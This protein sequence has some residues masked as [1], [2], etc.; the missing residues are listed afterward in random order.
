MESR[1]SQGFG[2][3]QPAVEEPVV[4]RGL[5]FQRYFSTPG[6][7]P[8]S[9]VEW[10]TRSAVITNERGEVV[11]EQRDVEVPAFWSQQATNIVVSKYF[12]GPLKGTG[13]RERSVRQLV[14]RVVD[15]IAS[16]ARAQR[17]FATEAD[18]AAFHDD[19]THLMLFQKAAFN[20]P[21]WFNCGIEPHPQCSA[22]FI[23][24]VEDT[25]DSILTLAK[26]EGM[27]FK[28]GSGT[29]TNLSTLRSS[30]ES[31]AGGGTAS[32]PVSFMKGYD[33]FAG[34]IKSGGKTRRAAKM[35][36]LNVDHP[37]IVDFIGCKVAEEKKAWALIDAGYDGS[38]TG[39]A[40]SSVFFQNSNNSVRVPDDFMRAV[41]DGAEWQTKAVCDGRPMETYRAAEIMRMIAEATYIC[42]DPGM[43]FDTTINEWHTCPNSGRINASNPCSEYMFLD[44][45]ACNLA[46]INLMRFVDSR[47]EFDV[48]AFCAAIRT[49]ITAQEI[50]VDNASYP[51][52]A[53]ERNSHE[54]RPLGLGYANLGALLMSRGLPY[55]SDAGRDYAAAITALMTGEAY[56][57]SARIARDNGGPFAGYAKNREPFLRVMAKHR[58]AL[59]GIDEHH[60]PPEIF[61]AARR[62]WDEAIEIGSVHGFRNAQT[63][64][65]APTGTIGFM[66]DCD[67]TGI[68]PDIALVKYKKLVDGGLLKIVNQTVP[69][70][71]ARLGYPEQAIAAIVDYIDRNETI[72]GAPFLKEADLAVFDCAFKPAKG[73]RSI[74]YLGHIRMMG[75]VQPFISGA[76]SKTV[77]VPR[78]ASVDEIMQAYLE[79]WRLGVK[80]IS[81]YRDG[82]KRTQPL[83]TSKDRKSIEA[84]VQPVRR[85]LP[86][87]RKAITHKFDIAGHEGYITVGLYED[88]SPGEIFLVMAK[89]GSTISG[90]ADAF[91]QAVSYALQYGVPLQVLVD[92]FSHVRFE[93]SGVTRNPQVRIAKSIVDYVFRWLATKFLS[94]EA[95]FEAG[96]NSQ[97][98]ASQRAGS[99]VPK[100]LELEPVVRGNGVESAGQFARTPFA[101]MQNQEDAP[102]CTTCGSI[103]VRSGSCYKCVNCGSTS[104]CA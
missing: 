30:R 78:E 75:A 23:N 20:S 85:K 12:R 89:E 19:L 86:D 14:G 8:Y 28:F 57:Q 81:I 96:V 1:E 82:S 68:E 37:D 16:W 17:Y 24:S 73:R 87:E 35:V 74:H 32:G 60:V 4:K 3:G 42:G 88:G 2:V 6:S 52:K 50:L 46:S 51:T 26:T 62:A 100:Q 84:K 90:F 33:A 101:A 97:A 63:T 25:L 38:F 56:A 59:R 79:A 80:A 94:P 18:L 83:N 66:M 44:D 47:G 10:E 77:N 71:L 27:L 64:V 31:L 92:K 98:G 91:A 93:P 11:F 48:Q 36:I 49:L 29:G 102:P 15:T 7:D 41:L 76:I 34:V 58:D 54:Y 70:A 72:E 55:D 9:E 5:E 45:S 95:Q 99:D 67:T 13:E 65:L 21:V 22:C 43:Q 40:Y 61:A 39:Q 69:A 104:G 53:I 103:M